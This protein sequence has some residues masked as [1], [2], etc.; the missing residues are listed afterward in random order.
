MAV[1][2][3]AIEKKNIVVAIILLP[4]IFVPSI[5]INTSVGDPPHAL[6]HKFI[7]I[8]EKRVPIQIYLSLI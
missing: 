6:R 4:I 7:I 1:I 3:R 8:Y 5:I 2:G